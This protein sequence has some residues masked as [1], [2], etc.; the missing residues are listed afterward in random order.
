[1][2]ARGIG[3]PTDV[4]GAYTDF[5]A[6]CDRGHLPGCSYLGALIATEGAPHYSPGQARTLV[7]RACDGGDG[8]GC[9][10]YGRL[11]EAGIGG[12]TDE[13]GANAAYEQACKLDNVEACRNA[14]AHF[15]FQTDDVQRG[16]D[17]L[18][19][20]C[21][22]E[23][24]KSCRGLALL[25]QNGKGGLRKN[26]SEAARVAKLACDHGDF[27]GCTVLGIDYAMGYSGAKDVAAGN[28]LFDK[29]CTGGTSEADASGCYYLGQAYQRG[30]GVAVDASRAVE[31]YRKACNAGWQESC[32]TLAQMLDAGDGVAKDPEQA[33]WLY[34]KA[35]D[36]GMTEACSRR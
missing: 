33:K 5:T 36:G 28:A 26:A 30:L 2:T 11:L 31:L 12:A 16:A 24:W 29:A 18:A 8:D 22:F 1:M 19:K 6:L 14:G 9:F 35:C 15:A 3:G 27:G 20:A 21:A 25:L 17:L 23:D 7:K 13:A 4:E 32:L 10:Y 34:G